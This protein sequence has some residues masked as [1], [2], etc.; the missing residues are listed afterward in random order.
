MLILVR[1][2]RTAANAQGLL[3]GRLDVDL[4]A[5]G[6]RQAAA[7]AEVL[8]NVGRVVSSP[9]LRA[10]RTAAAIAQRAGLGSDVAI[11][12]RWIEV[13]Y[14]A[15]DGVAMR[16]VPVPVLKAWR[17]DPAYVPAGGESLAD[18][19]ARL[20]PALA[21]LAP[22]ASGA[23]VV[24]VSHASPIKTAMCLALGVDLA[25][26]W[27]AHLDQGSI[28]RIGVTPAGMVLRSFNETGHL[29]TLGGAAR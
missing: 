22:E 7:V 15:Y 25:V 8:A 6:E 1:H 19:A 23:D 9:L 14:G 17:A 26:N 10:R 2:G 28:T 21:D 12:E 18:L 16:D 20:A 27:R 13:D 29:A 3:C 24:V 5:T 11:D 4:D